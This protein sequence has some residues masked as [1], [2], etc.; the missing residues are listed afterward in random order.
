MVTAVAP[1]TQFTA[2]SDVSS[3]WAAVTPHRGRLLR[4]AES[5]TGCPHDAE[6][7]V[8]EALLRCV[9]FDQLD[10]ARVGAL[11]TTI[12]VRLCADRHRQR[13][14]YRRLAERLSAQSTLEPAAEERVCDR[15]EAAWA[16]RHVDALP[17]RQRQV[18][19]AHAEGMSC[20]EVAASYNLPFKAVE[21]ALHRARIRL[22]TIVGPA[23]R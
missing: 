21:S 14:Q 22:R 10:E 16:V 17:A 12:T 13:E 3:R 8:Q 19:W 23:L 1:A 7:C 6:D 15:A 5:R 9:E 2:Q 20:A 18:L 11:L 4:I